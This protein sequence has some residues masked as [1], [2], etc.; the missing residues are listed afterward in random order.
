MNARG[1][2]TIVITDT[3]RR[4]QGEA[5][6]RLKTKLRHLTPLLFNVVSQLLAY[7]IAVDRGNDVDQPRNLAKSVT[8][9]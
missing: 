3:D 2:H 6:I 4:V 8:V 9:E 7:Y 1:A 5:V